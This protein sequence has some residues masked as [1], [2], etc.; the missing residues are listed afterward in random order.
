MLRRAWVCL[1]LCAPVP[2]VEVG[3]RAPE[4]D[5]V[6]WI[7]LGRAKGPRIRGFKGRVLLVLF[8]KGNNLQST[9]AFPALQDLHERLADR[10]AAVAAIASDPA[11]DVKKFLDGHDYTIP[12]AS[13]AGAVADYEVKAWPQA[14]LVDRKGKVAWKGDPYHAVEEAW[15]ILGLE[16]DSGKLLTALT[17]AKKRDAR[18]NLE[19]LMVDANVKFDLKAWAQAQEDPPPA[20]GAEAPAGEAGALLAELC[21]GRRE[22]LTGL[23]ATAP[24]DFNL[25][26]WSRKRH[27]E[28]FPLT[29][30]E[31]RGLLKEHRYH[32]A[33]DALADR[34]PTSPLLAAAASDKDF[35]RYCAA[36]SE[37]RLVF[38]R[39]ALMAWH[40]PIQQ[41]VPR[42]NDAFWHDLSVQSWQEDDERHMTGI[43]IGPGYVAGPEMPAYWERMI[44]QHL[45]MARIAAGQTS[46]PSDFADQVAAE[47]KRLLDALNEKYG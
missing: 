46:L 29:A 35:A 27:A 30:G 18:E 47:A 5:Q 42:N 21:E 1:L 41:R 3:D 28:L 31:L 15:K 19:L 23:R 2:A 33:L 36:R 20:E 24:A 45:L 4:L 34:R 14:F 17:A 7:N 16:R 9:M 39:K 40:W 10:G 22:A 8:W 13:D 44:A 6:E 26:A 11:D 37:E 25:K 38:A 12:T 32:A 43:Q